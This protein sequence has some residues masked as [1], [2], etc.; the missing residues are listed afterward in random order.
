[1]ATDMTQTKTSWFEESSASSESQN[2]VRGS[3]LLV[4]VSRLYD[5]KYIWKTKQ[6]SCAHLLGEGCALELLVAKF[7]K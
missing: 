2:I 7:E 5:T 1:M 3:A 6:E 4:K